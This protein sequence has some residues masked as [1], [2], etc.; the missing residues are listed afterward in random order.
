MCDAEANAFE[1]GYDA[2]W[3]GVDPDD[4]PHPSGT[5]QQ[6]SWDQGWSQ[7]QLEDSDAEQK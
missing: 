6:C 4:N 7:A 5:Q 3:D 2:Y 1:E